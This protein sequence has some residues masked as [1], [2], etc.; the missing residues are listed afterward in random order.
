MRLA[1]VQTAAHGGLL[2]YAAQLAD[3][4]AARGHDVE[5]ITARGNELEGRTG[6]ARMRAVLAA[7]TAAATEAPDG[8]RRVLRRARIASRLVRA[9]TRVGWELRRGRHDAAL[10]TD[11]PAIPLVA[12][13]ELLLTALPACPELAAVCHEPRPRNR[14]SGEDLYASSRA[15]RALLLR[16]YRRLDLVLV[17]GERSR[18][19][20]LRAWPSARVAIIPHGDERILAPS[21]P[22]PADEERIL[23]FGDW[24]RAKGLHVLMSA[25]ERLEVA[26][27]AARMT[28]AGT[29]LPDG[30]PDRVRRWAAARPDRVELIDSYVPIDDVPALF[31]RARV[32]ATPYLAGSQSGVLHLAM[33]M[34]RAVVASDAGELGTTVVDGVTGRVTPAGDAGALAAALAEVVADGEL[35]ARLGA[36]GRRRLLAESGWER[37]AER[38]EAELMPML[39]GPSAAPDPAGEHRIRPLG[40]RA[41]RGGEQSPHQR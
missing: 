13:A 16:L 1:V 39:R 23:Y 2:H 17:H 9:W 24:R 22:P 40:D 41:G 30:E 35:A 3:A 6:A 29:P 10:L 38:V 27:P 19:E 31:G 37:V 32:V 33:T 25:F 26:R 7:P 4:L 8:W 21:P 18:E 34:Q 15:L 5:L 11:D 28:I 20:L 12:A 14:W 36:E